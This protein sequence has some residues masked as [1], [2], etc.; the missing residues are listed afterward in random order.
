MRMEALQQLGSS[1]FAVDCTCP[2]HGPLR[3]AYRVGNKIGWPLD[4]VGANRQLLDLAQQYM[5]DIA[6]ID[7]GLTIRY[8]TLLRLRQSV[9]NIR[10]V[11]YSPDDMYGKHNQS[12]SYLSGIPVY[13]LHVTTKSYNVAELYNMGARAV[14]FVNNAFCSGVH[15][16]MS[17]SGTER[18]AFGGPVGFIG[19]FE[20]Y[21]AEAIW[22]LVCNGIQVRV[23]GAV[24]G[25]GWLKWGASHVHSNLR[26]ESRALFGDEYAKG[27]CSFDINLCFLRRL[28]RDLQTTRSVEIPA[29]GAFMLAERTQEHEALF[30]ENREVSFFATREEL[31]QK[32][33]YYLEHPLERESIALAGR[34]RCIESD[35]SYEGHVMRVLARLADQEAHESQAE[36]HSAADG[37]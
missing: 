22:F 4:T 28:N 35:Y 7:K 3:F 1:V 16:P 21:R 26:I 27:I 19:A 11:H 6:W 20:S 5:P 33:R 29:C 12:R 37:P 34:R 18:A 13:D 25:G 15:R 2:P 17:V 24:R 32:C 8:N 14:L 10:L 9:P 31:L 23:W 36:K 30:T